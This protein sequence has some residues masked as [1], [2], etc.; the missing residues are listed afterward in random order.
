M[1]ISQFKDHIKTLFPLDTLSDDA[2]NKIISKVTVHHAK[3]GD[4]LF[5]QGETDKAYVYLLSGK[6]GFYERREQKGEVLGGSEESL[7]PVAHQQPRAVTAKALSDVTWVRIESQTLDMTVA[8]E[9]TRNYEIK[10]IPE[11]PDADTNDWM[12][13]LLS[14]PVF[15]ATPPQNLQ[16]L[17]SKMQ[18][19]RGSKGDVIIHQGERPD[20]FYILASGYALVTHT[21]PTHPE[22]MKLAILKAGDTFGEDALI[23]KA[24]RNATVTLAGEA[25]LMKLSPQD[26]SLVASEA[27]LPSLE[28]EHAQRQVNEGMAI[29]LDTRLPTEYNK[30]HLP[31]AVNLPLMFL[32]VKFDTEINRNLIYIAYS[33]HESRS[34]AAAFFL[35]QRGVK[36]YFLKNGLDSKRS[37]A[38]NQL[39]VNA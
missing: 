25:L 4:V 23:S 17:F 20:Y 11:D 31:G 30:F 35:R 6:L 2:Y 7:H 28:Y 9:R 14:K 39:T 3:K 36:A 15:H 12:T 10:E 38:P 5:N 1:E 24:P 37:N 27:T 21:T 16:Q 33:D 26:L 18:V 13:R 34:T 19:I 22:G 32:R 29:W 8:W